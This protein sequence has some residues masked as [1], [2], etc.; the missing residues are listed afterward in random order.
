[1]L[2]D[3]NLVDGRVGSEISLG[4]CGGVQDIHLNLDIQHSFRTRNNSCNCSLQHRNVTY[5]HLPNKVGIHAKIFVNKYMAHSNDLF[6]LN[7][8]KKIFGFRSN[9]IGSFTNDLNLLDG[10]NLIIELATNSLKS[11]FT[12]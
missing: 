4:Q 3:G 6:P 8:G 11:M 1:M 9:V 7:L 5:N 2:K 12:V 10:A